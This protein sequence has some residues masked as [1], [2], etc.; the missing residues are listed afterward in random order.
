MATEDG[1]DTALARRLRGLGHRL[2]PVV[3]VGRD[4]LSAPVVDS[5]RQALAARELIKVRFGRG[6]EGEPAAAARQ[7]ATTLEAHLVQRIG[8][9][10][11]YWKPAPRDDERTSR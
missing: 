3:Q 1:L 2:R 11:L 5:A 10:A 9:V 8:R 7:L 6:F 4:G